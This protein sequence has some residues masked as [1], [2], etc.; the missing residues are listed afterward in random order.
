MKCQSLFSE[1]DRKK[2]NCGL[3]YLPIEWLRLK[4]ET[5]QMYIN[6]YTLYFHPEI[7]NIYI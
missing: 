4:K 7:K 6:V 5:N 3:L 2:S 1:K